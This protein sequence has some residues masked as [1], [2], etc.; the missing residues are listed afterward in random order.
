VS[1]TKAFWENKHQAM[2]S[3]IQNKICNS[4][5]THGQV[6]ELGWK[7]Q[8]Q[9]LRLLTSRCGLFLGK[10]FCFNWFSICKLWNWFLVLERLPGLKDVAS[11]LLSS[12]QVASQLVILAKEFSILFALR[13]SLFNIIEIN[14]S[15]LLLTLQPVEMSE[16]N[17]AIRFEW[18][19]LVDQHNRNK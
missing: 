2:E 14:V 15:V 13:R 10:F 3:Q 1:Q 7:I 12:Q 18:I 5:D 16:R 11:P 8:R 6:I 17:K 19:L 9:K 4:D